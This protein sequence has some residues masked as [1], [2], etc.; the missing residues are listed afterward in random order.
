MATGFLTF[1]APEPYFDIGDT[2]PEAEALPVCH[3]PL[4]CFMLFTCHGAPK[5]VLFS[6]SSTIHH[7]FFQN[8]KGSLGI[9]FKK[10]GYLS[11]A[12]NL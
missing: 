8:S 7:Y 3:L 1:I 2:S 5:W 4:G 10:V 6:A 11:H 12:V 9:G